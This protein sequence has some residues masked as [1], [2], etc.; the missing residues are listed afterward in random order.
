MRRVLCISLLALA[1]PLLAAAVAMADTL[2]G[3]DGADRL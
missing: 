3:T 1:L 2:V